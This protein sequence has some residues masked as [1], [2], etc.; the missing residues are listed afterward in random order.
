M[1]NLIYLILSLLSLIRINIKGLN[2]FFYDYMDLDNTNSLK[3][4]FVWMIFFRH[5]CEYYNKDLKVN[6]I[7]IKIDRAFG[8]N[9]VSLFLF[10]SGYGINESINKKGKNYIKTLPIK[11]AIIF[12]KYQISLLIYLFN[13]IIIGVKISFKRY[14]KA[15]IFKKGIG[16]SIWFSFTIIML[17]I[18][19]FLSFNF[20]KEKKHYIFGIFIVSIINFI[21]AIFV[22]KFYHK[23]EIIWVDTIICFVFG[24]YYSFFKS[25]INK[26]IMKN[27][28]TYFLIL[29]IH[30]IFY[31]KYFILGHKNICI[32][33][34]KNGLF[35]FIIILMSMKMQFKNEFLNLLSTYSY[36]IYLL[37]RVVMLHVYKK[38]YLKN[39][40]FLKFF[41]QFIIVIILAMVF[42]KYTI[43]IDKLLK[44]KIIK[45]RTINILNKSNNIKLIED[46]TKLTLNN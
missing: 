1:V 31:S 10:Y 2:C 42:D 34:I 36:G 38:G 23:G 11:S 16:N 40:E 17:Y 12:I 15:V 18:Y 46:N 6:K 5:C 37:Q 27:D 19:S 22:F 3:G 35:A 4:I 41:I 24:F 20:I 28:T 9:I 8:Q 45:S 44:H 13:N 30:I 43:F 14:I 25:Y 21:H 32:I 29:I 7:S 26:I 33:S 39:N